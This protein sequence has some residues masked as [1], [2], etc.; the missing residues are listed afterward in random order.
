MKT[1]LSTLLASASVA[2][3]SDPLALT[4]ADASAWLRLVPAGKFSARDG[5]GPFDA[6]G[7]SDMEA[8]VARTREYHG[9][10]DILVDYDHQSVFGA[11]D[12][13]GGTARAAGWIKQLEVRDDG[14]YGRV[15]W[16]AAAAAAIKA[17]EY[18][19]FSPV[20]PHHK[21]S[22]RIMLLLNAAIT[23]TPALQVDTLAASAYFP[24]LSEEGKPMEKILTALGLA[25]GSG[26]DAVLSAINTLLTSASAVAAAAG[27]KADAKPADVEAAV[28]AAF[29][30]RT[31]LVEAVGLKADA[32]PADIDTA[33]AALSTSPDPAKF[34]PIASVTALQ[35]QVKELKDGQ[36]ERDANDAVLTAIK[37]G[38][39]APALKD[40][41]LDLFKKDKTQFAAFTANAPV[42][43]EPQLKT[44]KRDTDGVDV[45]NP[46]ALSAAAT[47]YKKKM[48]D[49]GTEIDYVTAVRHVQEGKK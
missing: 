15:E 16:T 42:L 1:G 30:D 21:Q 31:K 40:W 33:I 14:I 28:K 23:N 13:V 5:R 48:A 47:A 11:K 8:I 46:V 26:E 37:D 17:G 27:L 6:G 12:G 39:L 44:P 20:I 25:E 3:L 43:T 19:Y 38:K 36:L 9:S 18:R 4:G 22:G 35:T 24:K 29:A 2:A 10:T 49:A 7:R 41:A 45:T 34:V 32:K